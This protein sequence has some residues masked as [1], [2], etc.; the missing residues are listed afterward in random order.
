MER[1]Q[2]QEIENLIRARYPIIYVVSWEEHRVEATLRAV[3]ERRRKQ[4]FI[5]TTT[6]GLQQEG[7]RPRTDG[8]TDPLQAMDEVMKSQDAAIFLFKDFHRFLKDDAQIVRKLRDLAYHLKRSYKSVVLVSPVLELPT[9][10]EKEI[11]VV[12]YAL[13]TAD[14]IRT[15]VQQT[16]EAT[17]EDE[18]LHCDLTPEQLDQIVRAAQGLTTI[19]VDNVLMK[20]LVEKQCLD[21]DV[22][23]AEKEQIIRKSGVLEYF[24]TDETIDDVGGLDALKQWLMKRRKAFGE[25]A[26]EYGLPQPKGLLLIGVQGCGKSLTAKAV[27]HLWQL[28]LLRLDVGRIFS[29]IVGSSEERMRRAISTAESIAPV[30]LWLDEVEKGFSGTQSSSFSDAGTTSRVFGSF[31]TWLQEK[32]SPV[33]VIATANNI[34]LLPPELL[35]KGRFDEI[36]FIDL[37]S[38]EERRQIVTIHVAKRLK[39]GRTLEEFDTEGIADET[40]A[41]SG[42]EI[43][44]AVVSAMY[45]AFDDDGRPF[46]TEDVLK[47]VR[48][49][50]PLAVTMREQID[51]LREWAEDRARP[52]STEA[53]ENGPVAQ[54]AAQARSPAWLRKLRSSNVGLGKRH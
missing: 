51:D 22:I 45:D 2:A 13:P 54:A 39:T 53:L 16:A 37:P 38:C 42:A 49:T 7:Q 28:P 46:T 11:T 33:F 31:V 9:E 18:R 4:L 35:R 23:L 12:D 41:F 15:Q 14:E 1:D 43:E 50:F 21:A 26:R 10:L 36:F 24:H 27:A 34:Q 17:K 5:W 44:Q 19:E 3:A 8:T 32:E 47:A 40:P 29:G 48:E 30:V 20:S 25:A 6:N 52:A